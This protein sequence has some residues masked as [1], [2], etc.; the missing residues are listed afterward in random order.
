MN[1]DFVLTDSQRQMHRREQL[2]LSSMK[3]SWSTDSLNSLA[4]S[5]TC[6]CAPTSHAGSFKCRYHR[7]PSNMNLQAMNQ[8]STNTIVE[9][10]SDAD[11]STEP[12]PDAPQPQVPQTDAKITTDNKVTFDI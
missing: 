10:K 12:Q 6:M 1:N 7:N 5:R 11:E 3:K 9:E 8:P 2:K 4:G